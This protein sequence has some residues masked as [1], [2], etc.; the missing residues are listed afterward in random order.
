MLHVS[1]TL[2]GTYRWDLDLK[3][4]DTYELS[5]VLEELKR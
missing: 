4:Y 1:Q 2:E 3:R 5:S